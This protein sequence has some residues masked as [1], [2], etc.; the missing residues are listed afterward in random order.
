M[1]YALC[2]DAASVRDGPPIPTLMSMFLLVGEERAY[3]IYAPASSRHIP[4]DA[5]HARRYF[6]KP[7]MLV[8][9]QQAMAC[10][11]TATR[12]KALRQRVQAGERGRHDAWQLWRRHAA[13]RQNADAADGAVRAAVLCLRDSVRAKYAYRKTQQTAQN[14]LSSTSPM[15]Q[16]RCRRAKRCSRCAQDEEAAMR[17]RG[18]ENARWS[19]QRVVT[20]PEGTMPETDCRPAQ[21]GITSV[22]TSE[23]RDCRAPARQNEALLYQMPTSRCTITTACRPHALSALFWRRDI[24]HHAESFRAIC[25]Q[26]PRC[27]FRRF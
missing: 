17:C 19:A 8:A 4:F 5:A 27:L 16:K 18:A 11:C 20:P 9:P 24:P 6:R 14:G 21:T 23:K 2:C 15:V 22:Q 3:F 13:I 10:V 26:L 7:K 25:L 1:H 12:S